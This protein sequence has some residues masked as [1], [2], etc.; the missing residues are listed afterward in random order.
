MVVTA[1][2]LAPGG[3]VLPPQIVL[4]EGALHDEGRRE[5]IHGGPVQRDG[6]QGALFVLRLTI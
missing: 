1:V 4:F 3:D 6:T 5:G 2:C